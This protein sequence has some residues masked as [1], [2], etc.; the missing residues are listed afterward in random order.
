MKTETYLPL[1]HPQTPETAR[2]W[3]K[4]NGVCILHWARHFGFSRYTVFDLLRRMQKGTRGESHQAAV[5]LG[6]KP[7]PNREA[8]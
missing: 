7:N 3:F 8:A 6:L 2:Q 4:S 1:P 5:A